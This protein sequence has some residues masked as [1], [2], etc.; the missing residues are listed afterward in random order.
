[1]PMDTVRTNC[2]ECGKALEFP[3]DFDNVICA[4]CGTAYLVR[5]Y[6]GAINLSVIGGGAANHRAISLSGNGSGALETVELR[7]SELDEVIADAELQIEALRSA[8][9]SA[10]LQIGCSF[11]GVFMALI[12][13]IVA[14]MPLGKAY[15]GGWLFDLALA[16]VILLGA[17]RVRSKLAG[18]AEIVR[19]RPERQRPERAL[20]Q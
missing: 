6:K 10:P 9:Q 17:K 8:E 3:R 20:D 13:V 18:P 16:A 12:L 4:G 7:L 15:F 19:V 2:L 1:M 11:F 5:E 14:F